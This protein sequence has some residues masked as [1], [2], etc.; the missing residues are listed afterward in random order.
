MLSLN[1]P[2]ARNLIG[3]GILCVVGWYWS[4][5]IISVMT[6]THQT[7]QTES[8]ISNLEWFKTS[9]IVRMA[10]VYTMGSWWY[11]W[12]VTGRLTPSGTI[13]IFNWLVMLIWLLLRLSI[14]AYVGVVVTPFCLVRDICRA[15]R[16]EEE[17]D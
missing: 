4:E 10:M 8:G 15:I 5:H 13:I 9:P 17:T 3:F 7:V 1:T 11:G 16:G 14:A 2:S 12:K 6:D